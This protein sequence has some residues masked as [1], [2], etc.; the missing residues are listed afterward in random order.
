[1]TPV[2]LEP[3]APRSRVKHSTTEPLRSLSMD[4]VMNNEQAIE[5]YHQLSDVW[6]KAAMYARKWL[7]NSIKVLEEI[8]TQDRVKS[9]NLET[10]HFP[11]MKTL[12]VQWIAS[13]ENF[14]FKRPDISYK[15]ELNHKI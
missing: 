14:H 15:S 11:L 8:P 2:R 12:G 4:L 10:G 1:M 3:A 6:G 9:V 5:L 13:E 7:S